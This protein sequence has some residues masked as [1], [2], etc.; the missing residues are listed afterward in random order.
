MDHGHGRRRLGRNYFVMEILRLYSH[1][2]RSSGPFFDFFTTCH[3]LF[4]LVTCRN[5]K[6]DLFRRAIWNYGTYELRTSYVYSLACSQCH[7]HIIC[8]FIP[9]L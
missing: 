2:L 1:S 9:Q 8:E 7:E 4:D 6:Y 5:R 3:N